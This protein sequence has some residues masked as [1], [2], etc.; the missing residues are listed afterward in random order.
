MKMVAMKKIIFIVRG[1]VLLGSLSVGSG[2]GSVRHAA[3]P[4]EPDVA[5]ARQ[6]LADIQE[7]I[8]QALAE[9][10]GTLINDLVWGHAYR[11]TPA[12]VRY[13]KDDDIPHEEEQFVNRRA[14]AAQRGLKKLLGKNV[15]KNRMPTIALA[16]SGGGFRAM[17]ATLGFLKGAQDIGLLDSSYYMAGL[18]G[19]SWAIAPWL[20]SKKS[21]HDYLTD[22][23][24][25]LK[26]GIEP[27]SPS[28]D[29][30]KTLL[31]VFITKFLYGQTITAM[32]IYGAVLANLLLRHI[33]ENGL[34]LT[35]SDTHKASAEGRWPLPIY[36]AVETTVTPYEWMEVT[37]FE[38]GSSY[39]KSY[40]PVWSFGRKF[41][42]GISTPDR[43]GFAPEQTLGYF[44]AV[45]GSAFEVSLKDVIAHSAEIIDMLM[46]H[47][48]QLPDVFDEYFGKSMYYRLTYAALQATLPKLLENFFKDLDEYIH[49]SSLS[50]ARLIPDLQ[51]NFTYDVDGSPLADQETLTMVD[52]GIAFNLPIP[53]LLRPARNVDVIIAYDTS[54]AIASQGAISLRKAEQYARN[55]DLK[56][57][58]IDYV[59]AGKQLV[60]VFKDPN[61]P[62]V[63]TVIYF[64]LINNPAYSST[65]TVEKCMAT[66][67]CATTN[68]DYSV[69]QVNELAGLAEFTLKQH[70][71]VIRKAIQEKIM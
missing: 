47:L 66:S 25:R 48:E 30:I 12:S 2:F 71:D 65:F 42:N 59:K 22:L 15:P 64:P 68:F 60:S 38:I 23:S 21:V 14:I 36:T 19:S 9:L 43:L 45:F 51:P 31:A 70:A 54:S 49:S 50:N 10:P 32:D 11:S 8:Q 67:Y 46:I 63:P 24:V 4:P 1:I 3:V 69:D 34:S 37:P 6:E 35:L 55:H 62:E 58:A 28:K 33:G 27:L 17:T 61:D 29:L 44:L 18:S 5:D 57:P 56:F 41:S 7:R 53:P 26:G 20:A 16:F 13:T 40:V 52:A 39:L